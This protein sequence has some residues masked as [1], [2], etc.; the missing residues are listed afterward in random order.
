MVDL[1]HQ[2]AD[3]GE[4]LRDWEVTRQADGVLLRVK[5]RE[6]Y[7][8]EAA[9]EDAAVELLDLVLPR[10]YEPVSAPVTASRPEEMRGASAWRAC[11]E[12]VLRRAQGPTLTALP[13]TPD[14]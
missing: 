2:I 11:V 7:G 6:C 13:S 1:L 12:V 5:S 10:G 3:H 14:G 9:A 8:T 4:H